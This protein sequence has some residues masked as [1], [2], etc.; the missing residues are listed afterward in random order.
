MNCK[1]GDMAIVI[2]GEIAG[3]VLTCLRLANS[4]EVRAYHFPEDIAIWKVDRLMSWT[5]FW[6][7]CSHQQIPYCVDSALMP[8]RPLDDEVTERLEEI[9]L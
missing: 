3:Q 9:V 1:P 2:R 7:E 4:F 5:D 6:N 8:I